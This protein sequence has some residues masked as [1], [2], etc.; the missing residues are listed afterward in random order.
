MSNTEPTKKQGVNSMTVLNVCSEIRL[1]LSN[2]LLLSSLSLFLSMD[3]K[4]SK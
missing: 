2:M 4:D 1:G 3:V